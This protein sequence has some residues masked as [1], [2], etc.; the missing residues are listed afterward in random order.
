MFAG[1]RGGDIGFAQVG[2]DAPTDATPADKR[3]KTVAP[4]IVRREHLS[5]AMPTADRI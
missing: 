2:G 4:M 5:M 3:K 1:T